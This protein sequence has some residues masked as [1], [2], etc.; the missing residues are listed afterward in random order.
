MY[1]N[2]QTQEMLSDQELKNLLNC[3]FPKDTE[4]VEGWLYIHEA[5][6]ES[7]EGYAPVKDSIQIEDGKAYQTYRMEKVPEAEESA[8]DSVETSSEDLVQRVSIL[9]GCIKD[10]AAMMSNLQI[11]CTNAVNE[12]KGAK[13]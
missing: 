9:E 2:P 1:Y 11:Y 13:Q 3:S 6:P 5:R 12:V 10:L 8:S 7:E 4:S